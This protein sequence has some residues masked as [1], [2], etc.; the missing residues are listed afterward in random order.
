M[1]CH[2]EPAGLHTARW[3]EAADSG[4]LKKFGD[5]NNGD[6][7][8]DHDGVPVFLARNGWHLQHTQEEWPNLVFQKTREQSF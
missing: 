5:A 3:I 7:A 4:E 6:M 8:E 1:P 2:F